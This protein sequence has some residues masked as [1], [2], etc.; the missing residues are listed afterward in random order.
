M[1]LQGTKKEAKTWAVP[2]GGKEATENFESCCIRE[3]YEETGFVVDVVK[4]C[5]IKIMTQWKFVTL[6]QSLSVDK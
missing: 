3:V 4:K 2:S 5:Y 6:R 1:V